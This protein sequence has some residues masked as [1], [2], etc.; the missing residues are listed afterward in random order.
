MYVLL[1][2]VFISNLCRAGQKD[3]RLSFSNTNDVQ[4]RHVRREQK[5]LFIRGTWVCELKAESFWT[6]DRPY[7]PY[8]TVVLSQTPDEQVYSV[9]VRLNST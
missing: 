2:V 3:S 4:L 8:E 9:S 7:K 5:T 6:L 1:I